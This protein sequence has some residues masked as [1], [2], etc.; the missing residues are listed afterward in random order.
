MD[1]GKATDRVSGL[2]PLQRADQVPLDRNVSELVL[3]GE[4]F[5]HPVFAAHAKSDGPRGPHCIGPVRLGNADD[6]HRMPPS[7]ELLVPAARPPD[8]GAAPRKVPAT[9]KHP[10]THAVV[11]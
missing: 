10:T 3:L 6:G 8:V 4:R 7:P 11:Y 9:A 1:E 5:L 2:V